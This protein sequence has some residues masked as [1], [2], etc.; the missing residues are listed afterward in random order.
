M[1]KAVN[2]R[3]NLSRSWERLSLLDRDWL[4]CASTMVHAKLC[5]IGLAHRRKCNL[6]GNKELDTHAHDDESDEAL[7]KIVAIDFPDLALAFLE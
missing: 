2:S 5:A 3:L 6:E 7:T 4:Y 1:N